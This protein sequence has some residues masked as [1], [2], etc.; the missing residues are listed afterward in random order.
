VAVIP[1]KITEIT[2]D[3]I[4][5]DETEL[6]NLINEESGE[7]EDDQSDSPTSPP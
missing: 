4:N 6:N 2:Y 5:I 1:A 7:D 3:E